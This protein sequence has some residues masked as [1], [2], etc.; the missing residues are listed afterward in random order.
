VAAQPSANKAGQDVSGA[1]P[2]IL[3]VEDD[4]IVSVEIENALRAA[5]F[6]VVGVVGAAAE[7]IEYARAS[8]PTLV[9]MDVRLRGAN[10][11]VD[12]ALEIYRETGA[13]SIF[14]TAHQ[15]PAVRDRAL[16]AAPLGWL[17]K[18]YETRALVELIHKVLARPSP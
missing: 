8:R 12:A 3:I 6:D 13:R 14:A 7:A 15:D 11:G 5:G 10:D 16:P 17:A 9:V 18:P 1:A 2:R 4:Y